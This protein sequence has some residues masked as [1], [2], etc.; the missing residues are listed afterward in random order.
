VTSLRD[1]S[2]SAPLPPTLCYQHRLAP[3]FPP[4][5]LL[6]STRLRTEIGGNRNRKAQFVDEAICIQCAKYFTV[7]FRRDENN[8]IAVGT[9]VKYGMLRAVFNLSI[10]SVVMNG[11]L[12]PGSRLTDVRRPHGDTVTA[13]AGPGH[14]AKVNKLPTNFNILTLAASVDAH[15]Q[16]LF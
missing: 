9:F 16:L 8:Y 14:K 5:V 1:L 12:E 7:Y 2:W 4:P 3:I 10:A 6:L 13:L 11:S 15:W